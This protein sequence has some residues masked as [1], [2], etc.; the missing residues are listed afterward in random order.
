MSPLGAP[1]SDRRFAVAYGGG[2]KLKLELKLKSHK[3][4]TF[5]V[6]TDRSAAITILRL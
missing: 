1:V 4:T 6:R 5:P 3:F 2:G